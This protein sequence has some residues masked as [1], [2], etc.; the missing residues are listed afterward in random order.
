MD[1]T[2]NYQVFQPYKYKGKYNSLNKETLN[3]IALDFKNT[4]LEKYMGFVLFF[5]SK[6]LLTQFNDSWADRIRKDVC[7]YTQNCLNLAFY[8][9]DLKL[10]IIKGKGWKITSEGD[11]AN[12]YALIEEYVMDSLDEVEGIF[13]TS[14][15]LEQLNR[16]IEEWEK[17]FRDF[18]CRDSFEF[19]D[20]ELNDDG[21]ED[22]YGWKHLSIAE[23]DW[24]IKELKRFDKMAKNLELEIDKK[25]VTR[26]LEYMLDKGMSQERKVY[27]EVFRLLDNFGLIPEHVISSHK[28]AADPDPAGNYIK[29]LVKTIQKNRELK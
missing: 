3:I 28:C 14:T 23:I 13:D 21:E 25:V 7:R 12:I 8:L 2:N 20:R 5:F 18:P 4:P 11:I 9:K 27:R 1:K 19:E 6:D 17:Q 26:F 10:G 29:S 16:P 24:L 22:E 15:P